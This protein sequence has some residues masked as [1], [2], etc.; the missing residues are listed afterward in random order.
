MV[1]VLGAFERERSEQ[2]QETSRLSRS[3][4]AITVN[5]SVQSQGSKQL[6]LLKKGIE[7]YSK[8]ACSASNVIGPNPREEESMKQL[9]LA[10]ALLFSAHLAR[11]APLGALA[12]PNSRTMGAT[13][14]STDY[15]PVKKATILH[16]VNIS[17]KEIVAL[18]LTMR[19]P[20]PDGTIATANGLTFDWLRN[21]EKIEGILPGGRYDFD[22][23]PRDEGRI[24]ATVDV[25]IYAD[26]AADVE[27]HA[28]Y[29][30]ILASRKGQALAKQKINDLVTDALANTP[31]GQRA[32]VLLDEIQAL[33]KSVQNAQNAPWDGRS[34]YRAEL[35]S[36]IQDMTNTSQGVLYSQ[37]LGNPEQGA[38][39]EASTLR[40]LIGRNTRQIELLTSHLDVKEV[41]P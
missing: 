41:R 25:V 32:A 7:I 17:Q 28:A 36:A 14:A 19:I 3:A 6:L 5:N 12:S 29:Q 30:R 22:V 4:D 2:H 1:L 15:D 38:A 16:I 21:A 26:D 8:R 33:Q 37:K 34:A 24:E 40:Y 9:F 11:S 35:A 13:V 18:N 20:M 31:E 23:P 27:N 39:Q 10:F